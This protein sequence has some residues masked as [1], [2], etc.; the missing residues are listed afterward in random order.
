MCMWLRA[1]FLSPLFF[2]KKVEDNSVLGQYR[3]I[4]YVEEFY[5]IIGDVHE[6]DLLHAGYK[7]TFDKVTL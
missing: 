1:Q 6:K 3:R 4:A 7:K 5:Q 2:I